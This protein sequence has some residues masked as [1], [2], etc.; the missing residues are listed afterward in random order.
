MERTKQLTLSAMLTALSV[1][2]LLFGMVVE[3]LDIA[4][5]LLASMPIVFAMLELRRAWPY[6]LWA[7][8]SAIM[9]LFFFSLVSLEY[10][11]FGGLYPILK[12]Y[13]EKLPLRLA[14]I[15]KLL[16]FNLLAAAVLF[17]STAALGAALPAEGWFWI[18]LILLAN[19][20]FL[21]YD[22]LMTRLIVRYLL[23]IR[24][25]I[26]RFLK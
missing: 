18:P 5:V 14:L 26:A 12:Y 21:I 25:G 11:F 15:P 20:T 13:F 7:A 2:I 9:L 8:T 23:S 24:P 6:L 4:A 1:V 10:A 19:L 17:L 16:S 3:V 22:L